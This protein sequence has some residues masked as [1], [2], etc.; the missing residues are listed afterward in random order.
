MSGGGSRSGE[1]FECIC[2]PGFI[3]NGF[4]CNSKP[5]NDGLVVQSKNELPASE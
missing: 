2:Q 1:S 5:L 3:G 4:I